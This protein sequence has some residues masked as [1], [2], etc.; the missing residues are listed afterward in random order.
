MNPTVHE[1]IQERFKA[2]KGIEARERR[3][4]AG[5]LIEK[6]GFKGVCNEAV[7]TGERSA[8]YLINT[9]GAN[10]AMVVQL[11]ANIKEK[12]LADAGVELHEEVT[13]V[14]F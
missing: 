4:P 11:A 9:G 1:G 12:V 10:A 5:W 14:G 3:V 8:N 7:C 13:L 6:S 2:E